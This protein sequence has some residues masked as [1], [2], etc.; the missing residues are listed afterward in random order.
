MAGVNAATAHGLC[1]NR[2]LASARR[3]GHPLRQRAD[4]L[5]AG[6]S[7]LSEWRTNL[8]RKPVGWLWR[9][10]GAHL[11]LPQSAFVVAALMQGS[12]RARPIHREHA[13]QAPRTPGGPA[14]V[15]T[16]FASTVGVHTV[17]LT[18]SRFKV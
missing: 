15:A 14:L 6:Q 16:F 8:V 18:R 13:G 10:A 1:G 11:R 4:G 7:E 5:G 3:Y 2:E 9:Q 17:G 12:Q